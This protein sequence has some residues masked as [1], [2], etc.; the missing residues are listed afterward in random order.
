MLFLNRSWLITAAAE[1]HRCSGAGSKSQAKYIGRVCSSTLIETGGVG[2]EGRLSSHS[3]VV[4]YAPCCTVLYSG[5]DFSRA[6]L[7]KQALV[8]ILHKN[9]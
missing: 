7:L 4:I 9:N 1:Q 6:K 5:V 3:P 8:N 2:W